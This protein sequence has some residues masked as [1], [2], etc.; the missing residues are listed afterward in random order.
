MR[1]IK[2]KELG[3]MSVS[4]N[5]KKPTDFKITHID[6]DKICLS[7]IELLGEQNEVYS[8]VLSLKNE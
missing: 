5:A 4:F 8:I 6:D 7:A 2:L 3:T 1:T